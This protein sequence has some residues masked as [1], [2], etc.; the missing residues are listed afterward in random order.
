V[1]CRV[2]HRR[3]LKLLALAREI[4]AANLEENRVLL[5]ELTIE[6]TGGRPDPL[7]GSRVAAPRQMRGRGR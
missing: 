6:P 3:R 5:G 1:P 7:A 4:L 2:K